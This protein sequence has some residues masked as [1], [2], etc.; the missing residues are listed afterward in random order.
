MVCVAQGDGE[1][2]ER[3][4]KPTPG[5][6][7]MNERF[8][9]AVQGIV[10]GVGFRPFIYRLANRYSLS[11]YVTNTP[12][13]VDIEI[14]GPENRIRQF[15]EAV[16]AQ[17]P[18]LAHIASVQWGAVPLQGEGAFHIRTSRAGEE[19]SALISP[20]V[21]VCPDCLR[22]MSDPSNRRF[23]YPFINCTNCGPR[24]TIIQDIPYD[25]STTTMQVFA[26]CPACRAEYEDPG[27]RRFHAQ[28]NAC[29]ECGPQTALHDADGNP[30]KCP[31]P[32][33]ESISLLKKGAIL[34]IKGLGGF[35]LATDASNH[36]AV[37]R[38]RRRKHREEKPLAIMV[39][40]LDDVY[41]LA[42]VSETEAKLLTSRQRPIVLL[43]KR[44]S[45][46]ISPQVAPKNSHVG[47]MLPYTPLHHLLLDEPLKA[48][49]MTSGNKTEEPINTK[50]QEA[51]NNLFG[52]ADYFLTHNR[53]I[54]LRADDSVMKVID[55]V[56]RQ[57]RR[58]RG[59]APGP[60][61]LSPD[62]S[63]LPSVLAVGGEL[64]NTIC[65]TKEN[66]A[67]MSQ[68]IGD[69]ENLE[70]LDFF[71]LTI[72]HLQRILEIQPE[73]VVHDLHPDYLSSKFAKHEPQ[74]PVV[75]VQHHHAHVV[76]C[77][78]EHGLAE[79]VIGVVL[80]GTGLGT[81]SRIWGGEIMVCDPVS[82]ERKGHLA[83]VSLPGGDAAARFPWR[84]ALSYL[85]E[86]FGHELFNL[87]IPFVQHLDHEEAGLIL[88]MVQRGINSPL[89][90]SCGRLFDGVASLIG[91]RDKIA[92]E[93][94]AAVELEMCQSYTENGHY[95]YEINQDGAQWLMSGPH[96]IKRVVDDLC[97]GIGQD[98][99]SRRF[100]NTMIRMLTDVCTRVGKETG[101]DRIA[102]SGGSFQ[103]MTLLTGLTH[104]LRVEGFKVY[105]HTQVPTNDGGLSLGQA[106]CG[107]LTYSGIKG[108]FKE[109]YEIRR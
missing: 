41:E 46:E 67:F 34:A 27:D 53:G 11:G 80:D 7:I 50:N 29:W 3:G 61:F 30:I 93:G 56:P 100:H 31:D 88:H 9:G 59:Y 14:Q 35:H 32:V 74:I 48:L 106:V 43:R 69:M 1:T 71:N 37:T 10:Q 4:L 109:S 75:A 90:S 49:V 64:K 101:V 68:H 92:H 44:R 19:R 15:I 95:P 47:I 8:K 28:P 40:Q 76:G 22:E 12:T 83:Y 39:K 38:L 23:Q 57:I 26:M 87:S 55:H 86:A 108:I 96:L 18:P 58:S 79:P 33:S 5:Q 6:P 70:T 98:I 51:F 20:D 89:T 24:Y 13:G 52:I 16:T 104:R 17:P 72:N 42:H 78:A 73:V 91:L 94:Q 102:L 82:F 62:L 25:R 81:D 85:Y 77:L 103:N 54:Y 66:R 21:S 84:M 97:A 60:L 105:S 45:L 99:I 107:G 63:P 36:Q 65:L 2:Q